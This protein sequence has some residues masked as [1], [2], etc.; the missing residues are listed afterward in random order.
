MSGK[1]KSKQIT[2]EFGSQVDQDTDPIVEDISDNLDDALGKIATALKKK[3]GTNK[4]VGQ[5]TAQVIAV[6]GPVLTQTEAAVVHNHLERNKG[7]ENELGKIKRDNLII[8]EKLERLE[9]YTRKDQVKIFG[10]PS[11]IGSDSKNTDELV[12]KL[13]KHCGFDDLNED[14]ISVSHRLP[15]R[16]GHI[17]RIIAK[18]VVRKKRD[19]FMKMAKE[20]LKTEK[21]SKIFVTENLNPECAKLLRKLK[22]PEDV[23]KGA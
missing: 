7:I 20:K 17:P 1:K 9:Q 23:K 8:S 21:D 12:V 19:K 10:I 18:F 11:Q 5:I 6:L 13:G 4:E 3:A 14:D 16:H 2:Q 15:A 22:Q